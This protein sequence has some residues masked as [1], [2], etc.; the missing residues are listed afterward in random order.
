MRDAF[1]PV[2]A[3]AGYGSPSRRG[4]AAELWCAPYC[5]RSA[6]TTEAEVLVLLSGGVDSTACVALYLE[7][8]RPP[9]GLFVDYGQRARREEAVAAEA[10]AHHY[11]ISL[12]TAEWRG[13]EPK[14]VGLIPARNIFLIAVAAMERPAS[15]RAIALGLHAGTPF[16]DSSEAFVNAVAESLRC[17]GQAD[18]SLATPFIAWPKSDVYAYAKRQRVPFALTYSCERDDGPC[19]LCLS[20]G[21]RRTLDARA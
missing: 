10:V 8:G 17:G 20:C 6:V 3:A 12:R 1:L 15:V 16:A 19:G 18:F 5:L 21:D 9:C 4:D 14:S 7:M 13:P 2:G 11:G